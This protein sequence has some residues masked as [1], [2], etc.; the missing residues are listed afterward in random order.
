[1]KNLY[2]QD[3]S[4]DNPIFHTQDLCLHTLDT[5]LICTKMRVQK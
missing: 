4:V 3:F 2:M 5:N 1:M